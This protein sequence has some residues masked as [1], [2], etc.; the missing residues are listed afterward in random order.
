MS[1]PAGAPIRVEIVQVRP[2]SVASV[3]ETIHRDRHD[4]EPRADVPGLV[5]GVLER[6]GIGPPGRGSRAITRSARRST[7]RPACPWRHRF[8][9]EGIVVREHAARRPHRSRD[10]HGH[11]RTAGGR[12]PG[13]LRLDRAHRAAR[14]RGTVGVIHDRPDERTAIPSAGAPT[15]TGRSSSADA[16]A[17]SPRLD[18]TG[19]AVAASRPAQGTSPRHRPD[20]CQPAIHTE[21]VTT[22]NTLTPTLSRQSLTLLAAG[23][24]TGLLAATLH[25]P[26]HRDRLAHSPTRTSS[27]GSSMSARST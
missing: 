2:Q 20:R 19:G 4:R 21:G 18:G 11:V 7:S 15:S 16:R 10:P 13:D 24:A 8:A 27:P 17:T 5:R 26:G 22:V 23:L 9:P 3:R 25:G 1:L 12:L 14:G 6:Q